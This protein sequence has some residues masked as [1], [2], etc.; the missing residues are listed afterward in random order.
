MKRPPE[1][2]LETLKEHAEQDPSF[3]K[4]EIATLKSVIEAYRAWS[5]LGKATKG[6]IAFLVLISAGIT[7]VNAFLSWI[8]HG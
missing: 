3:T 1:Q 7:V 4:E 5:V 8:R 6:L 2:V